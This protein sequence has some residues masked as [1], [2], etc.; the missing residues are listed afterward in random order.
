MSN[1]DPDYNFISS[2]DYDRELEER[3]LRAEF[4][5]V[6]KVCK[7]C[8]RVELWCVCHLGDNDLGPI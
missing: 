5:P 8:G 4:G 7:T 3:D 1:C 6:N 2:A